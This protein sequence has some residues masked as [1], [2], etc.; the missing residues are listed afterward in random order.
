MSSFPNS[1]YCSSLW[2]GRQLRVNR[3]L[4]ENYC[5]E[6]TYCSPPS[7]SVGT[8]NGEKHVTLYPSVDSAISAGAVLHEHSEYMFKFVINKVSEIVGS[9]AYELFWI[10]EFELG[11]RVLLEIL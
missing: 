8:I 5:S 9:E 4:T 10:G 3:G 6:F 2:C 11:T 7:W 1:I